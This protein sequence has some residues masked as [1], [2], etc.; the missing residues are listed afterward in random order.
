MYTLYILNI[1]ECPVWPEDG[2]FDE[3]EYIQKLDITKEIDFL[4]PSTDKNYTSI[5]RV[6]I[7]AKLF[8]ENWCSE[9]CDY[10]LIRED[11]DGM[12]YEIDV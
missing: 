3:S 1:N 6:A 7:H 2:N 9:D 11:S 10:K 5:L 12:K 8:E 4:E